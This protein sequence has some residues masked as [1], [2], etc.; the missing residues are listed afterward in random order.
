MNNFRCKNC[1]KE[2]ST[3]GFIGTHNRNHCPFCLYSLHVDLTPG[4]RKETCH[5][6]MKPIGLTF[7]EEGF[8]KYGKKKQGELMI[9]HRCEK[10]GK[11][12]INRIAADDDPKKI[13]KIYDFSLDN[14]ESL[15]TELEK[16]KV[17]PLT[18]ND[19][20]EIKRQLFG[21]E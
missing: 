6:S 11:I 21:R 8:D 5:G 10:C 17:K 1:N 9:I 4:D 19:L 2:I 13:M 3:D 15:E 7:K 20:E 14:M 16:E 18:K 12:N